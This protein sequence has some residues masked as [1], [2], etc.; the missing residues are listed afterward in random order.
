VDPVDPLAPVVDPDEL[1]EE[2]VELLVA[3]KRLVAARSAL[4]RLFWPPLPPEV[5]EEVLELE[6]EVLD[7]EPELE[8]ELDDE[9]A[10][11]LFPPDTDCTAVLVLDVLLLLLEASRPRP[12]WLPRN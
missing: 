8:V 10:V 7:V 6:L 1:P 5:P 2:V 12:D 11:E 3:P 9:D 4:E